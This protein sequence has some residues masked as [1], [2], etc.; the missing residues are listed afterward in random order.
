[1]GVGGEGGISPSSKGGG[2][3]G[4][5]PCHTPSTVGRAINSST[6]TECI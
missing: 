4:G 2:G 1:M 5:G 6:P 3:G